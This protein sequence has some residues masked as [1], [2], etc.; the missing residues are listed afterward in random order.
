MRAIGENLNQ[1]ARAVN[2]DRIPADG[3]ISGSVNAHIWRQL[4][5]RPS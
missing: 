4:P 1:I 2:T 5:W 3:N